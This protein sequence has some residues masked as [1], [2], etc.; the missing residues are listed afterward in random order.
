[1]RTFW[2][3]VTEIRD[4]GVVAEHCPYCDRLTCC[5]LRSMC[6]GHYVFFVKMADLSRDSS[7]MC[8]G[9]LKTFSGRPYWH[10]ARFIPIRDARSMELQDLLTQTNPILADR[11]QFN[12]QIRDLGG[13]DRFV[14]A[15]EHLE[16]MR[17]GALRR[18]RERR[19]FDTDF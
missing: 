19:S 13:D 1:M 12:Q 3:A 8:T 4:L 17:P 18:S 16:G 15:F 14:R 7:C 6:L 10:Y 5:L 9:C 2:G 11:I